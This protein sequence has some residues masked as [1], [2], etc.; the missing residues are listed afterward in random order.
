MT[1]WVNPSDIGRGGSSLDLWNTYLRD[2]MTH[3]K[4]PPTDYHHYAFNAATYETT[5]STSFVQID[6]ALALSLE[7][8]GGDVLLI[9]NAAASN[10]YLDF[11]VDNSR[12]GGTDGILA[13]PTLADYGNPTQLVWLVQNLVAGTHSFDVYWKVAS[14]TGSLYEFVPPSFVAREIS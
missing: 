14:G 13:V 6:A 1:D 11:V 9:F 4:A 2:N 5:T 7:T 8:F 12:Q 10:C 3:I